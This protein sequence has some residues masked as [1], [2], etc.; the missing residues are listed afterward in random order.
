MGIALFAFVFTA[1]DKGDTETVPESAPV[2]TVVSPNVDTTMV[3]IG[4][5]LTFGVDLSSENALVSLN[6][7]SNET[8]V[9]FLNGS[10]T[11]TTEKQTVV[12]VVAILGSELVDGTVIKISFTVVDE[13]GQSSTSKYIKA[14][15][16][17]TALSDAESLTWKRVGGT[18]ATGLEMFGLKW[19][20][21]SATSAIIKK[22]ADK[23]VKLESTAWTTITILE[24]LKVAVDAAPSMDTFEEISATVNSKTYDIS[25]A[26]VKDG[27]YYL[28]HITNSMVSVGSEGTTITIT[29]M[30]KK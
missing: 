15:K 3:Y 5:S 6:T 16:K 9:R 2:I 30:Y 19:T 27:I 13:K 11:F 23:F 18:A 17:A 22:D 1:C 20:S 10:K 28:I 24:D 7:V 4:D 14:V 25:L 12:D 26:T 8:G 29:G 21:N